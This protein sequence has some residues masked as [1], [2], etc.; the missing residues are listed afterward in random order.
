MDKIDFQDIETK[1]KLLELILLGIINFADGV[2][3]EGKADRSITT[4][5]T[6][7]SNETMYE[8]ESNSILQAFLTQPRKNPALLFTHNNFMNNFLQ[9]GLAHDLIK[10]FSSKVVD[11]TLSGE[12]RFSFF[13]VIVSVFERFKPGKAQV[14]NELVV[15]FWDHMSSS[16]FRATLLSDILYFVRGDRKSNDYAAALCRIWAKFFRILVETLDSPNEECKELLTAILDCMKDWSKVD[17]LSREHVFCLVIFLAHNSSSMHEIIDKMLHILHCESNN[18]GYFLAFEDLLRQ[19]YNFYDYPKN[20]MESV[21]FNGGQS[22][23]KYCENA[24]GLGLGVLGIKDILLPQQTCSFVE[25]RGEF[26]EQYVSNLR[27]YSFIH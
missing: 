14:S 16:K 21:K 6:N 27:F 22:G 12:L 8:S 26:T 20:S 2:S 17:S 18:I 1:G 9:E 10:F 15:D 25:T 23:E 7:F 5:C 4:N 3:L 19:I 13:Q 11:N 24:L